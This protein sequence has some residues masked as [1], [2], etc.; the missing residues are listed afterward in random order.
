MDAKQ[1]VDII[2]T[3]I[4]HMLEKQFCF[5]DLVSVEVLVDI[6]TEIDDL[7]LTFLEELNNGT[8]I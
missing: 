5:K 3:R 7:T 2:T 1:A 6:E 8:S 4:K